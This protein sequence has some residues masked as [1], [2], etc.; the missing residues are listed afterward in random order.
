MPGTKAG[1]LKVRK[2][3]IEKQ[4]KDF[5]KRIGQIGGKKPHPETR[6]FALHPEAA[7]VAGKKGGKISKRGKAKTYENNEVNTND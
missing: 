4:G 6:Y 3:N 2:T 5:Y 1:G 7:K